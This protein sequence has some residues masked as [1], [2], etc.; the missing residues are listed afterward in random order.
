MFIQGGLE[1]V[2]FVVLFNLE[3]PSQGA[4][5]TFKRVGEV[6]YFNVQF[7]SSLSALPNQESATEGFS[8]P[9]GQASRTARVF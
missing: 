2:R 9:P 7:K 4:K 6:T 1:H 5:P 3:P 8:S